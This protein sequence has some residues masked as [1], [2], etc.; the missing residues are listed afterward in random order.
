M[1][2]TTRQ[3]TEAD[4]D[5]LLVLR[6]EAMK[7]YVEEVYGWDEAFQEEYFRKSFKPQH[8]KIIQYAGI[9][10][11]MYYVVEEDD[12]YIIKRIEVLCEY[13]NR[14]IGTKILRELL[15]RAEQQNKAVRLRVFKINPARRLYERLGFLIMGE[16]E[17][18]YQMEKPNK[19]FAE[20]QK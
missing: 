17:T 9:D 20:E 3:V 16:T 11:G 5:F 4:Y 19:Q 12:C 2:I 7:G 6:N 18:H 14:G 1:K 8:K 10:V 13:Q 15:K